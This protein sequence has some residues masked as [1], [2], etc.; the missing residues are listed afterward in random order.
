MPGHLQTVA[1]VEEETYIG[2]NECRAKISDFA[3]HS[4]LLE[5][6]AFDDLEAKLLEYRSHLGCVISWV[7]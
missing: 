5:V 6:A 4:R 2:S 3:I 7:L 1:G